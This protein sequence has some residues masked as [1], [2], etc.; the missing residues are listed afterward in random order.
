MV[1]QI[2]DDAR[3]Q[4][5]FEE[6]MKHGT[7]TMQAFMAKNKPYL[8]SASPQAIDRAFELSLRVKRR[9]L[10]SGDTAQCNRF[11]AGDSSALLL[12]PLAAIYKRPLSDAL[13]ARLLA[14]LDGK[15]RPAIPR[16][17][18]SIED[19]LQMHLSIDPL[20]SKVLANPDLNDPRLC[21]AMVRALEVVKVLPGEVGVRLRMTLVG[22]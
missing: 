3:H 2:Q 17:W 4:V 21:G 5:S 10:Q 6:T 15:K 20:D 14:M 1:E 22:A 7:A 18:A 13:E 11:L 16:P 19:V 8:Q 9:L 12:P